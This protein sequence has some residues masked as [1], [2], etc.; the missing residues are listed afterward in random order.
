MSEMN[1]TPEFVEK[2]LRISKM[3]DVASLDAPLKTNGNETDGETFCYGDTIVSDEPSPY[4]RL[5]TKMTGEKVQ[6]ALSKF[7]TEKERT[8]IMYRFGFH[9]EPKTLQEV[10]DTFNPPLTRE[11]IRQIEAHAILKLKRKLKESDFYG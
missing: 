5:E 9:G 10:A 8:I 7:L 11:R 3:F 4:E 2:V 6:E 1:W